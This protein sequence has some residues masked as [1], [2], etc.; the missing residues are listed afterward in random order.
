M[1]NN[2]KFIRHSYDAMYRNIRRLNSRNS[3]DTDRLSAARNLLIENIG[4]KDLTIY[5]NAERSY[6]TRYLLDEYHIARTWD[7]IRFKKYCKRLAR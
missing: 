2:S 6:E 1:M 5:R 4:N 7:R 3:S